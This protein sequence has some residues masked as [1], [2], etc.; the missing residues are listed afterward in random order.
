MVENIQTGFLAGHSIGS[1]SVCPLIYH[2]ADN[3]VNFLEEITIKI[4]TNETIKASTAA[5]YLK[6]SFIT[7][8]RIEKIVENP[9][10]IEKY[11]YPSA[12][13]AESDILLITK[14]SLVSA[15]DNYISFKESTG[16][17]VSVVT[18]EDIYSQYSGDDDQDK[19][20]NCIIDYYENVQP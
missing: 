3:K 17:I 8:E 16:F 6:Q 20:R 10:M 14:N 7:T 5:A 19:I 1:F 9:G 18:V 12:K 4:T 2:P 15:F 11:A 13:D